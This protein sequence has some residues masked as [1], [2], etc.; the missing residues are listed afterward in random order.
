MSAL[1]R[2]ELWLRLA[3]ANLVSGELPPPGAPQAPWPVRVML[4]IAGWIGA[5]FLLGFAVVALGSSLESASVEAAAG[6]L[7]CITA[8]VLL[9]AVPRTDLVEQFGFAVSLSGQ[10]LLLAGLLRLAGNRPSSIPFLAMAAVEAALALAGPYYV[11]RVFATVAA[12]VCLLFAAA[13]LGASP[14]ATLAAAVGAA[15]I[16]LNPIRM[17]ARPS[18]WTPLGYGCAIALLHHDGAL[19]FGSGFVMKVLFQGGHA[20]HYLAWTGPLAVGPVFVY[21]AWQLRARAGLRPSSPG[22]LV[23]L[24]AAIVLALCGLAAPGITAALLVLALGVANGDR[25]LIGLGLLAFGVYLA[26]SYYELSF[27]LLT[28]SIALTA[29]GSALL[30]LRWALDRFMPVEETAHA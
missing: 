19:L 13:I 11:Y 23:A 7:C 25:F 21:V 8:Y 12:N 10:A 5:L 17:A 14:L 1:T 4:G 18:L 3:A 28:K 9:L 30:G 6:A 15:L 2:E 27:T 26:H 24:A 20:P 22:G 16:W 29:T